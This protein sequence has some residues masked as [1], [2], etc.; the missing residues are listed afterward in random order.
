LGEGYLAL[1]P[2]TKEIS[3]MSLYVALR[4]CYVGELYRYGG[5]V[6][7]LPDDMEKSEKNFMLM[8]GQEPTPEAV[9]SMASPIEEVVNIVCPVCGKECKSSFGLKAH[10]RVHTRTE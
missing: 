10:Q 7:E 9:E 2:S 6:Y 3:A 1:P 4:D 8:E 5:E